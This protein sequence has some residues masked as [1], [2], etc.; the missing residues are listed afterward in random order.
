M[1]KADLKSKSPPGYGR[2][3]PSGG[4]EGAHCSVA[5]LEL[6]LA[7]GDNIW[8]LGC[9]RRDLGNIQEAWRE[10]RERFWEEVVPWAG[11][12]R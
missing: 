6:G 8:T 5:L 3:L 1:A 4:V 7:S 11:S 9:S 10:W 12:G 2:H